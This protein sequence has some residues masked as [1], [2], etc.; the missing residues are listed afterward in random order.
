MTTFDM[1]SES[2]KTAAS[3]LE[4]RL[5]GVPEA[6]M[7][8]EVVSDFRSSKVRALLY[9]LAKQGQPQ[10][11]STLVALLWGDTLEASG[12]NSL[13]K[14][15]TNLRK[16]IPEFIVTDR[17][18]ASLN[19]E[20]SCHIDAVAF[21]GQTKVAVES[22]NIELLTETTNLYAGDFLEGF[23]V[24]DA[25]D[26]EEWVR[27]ERMRLSRVAASALSTL[28]EWQ[29]E[30]GDLEEAQATIRKSLQLEPWNEVAHQSLMNVLVAAGHRSAALAQYDQCCEILA[31]ELDV[32][33]SRQTKDLYEKIR[34]DQIEQPAR[35]R[36]QAILDKHVAVSSDE[37]KNNLP[38]QTTPFVGRTSEMQELYDLLINS[39]SRLITIVAPGGMGKTRLAIE[40]GIKNLSNYKDGVY[41]VPLV[42]LTNTDQIVENIADILSYNFASDN[43]TRR[44]QLRDYL[45]NK[46]TLLILDNFEHLL[47]NIDLLIDLLSGAPE[48]KFLVTSRERLSLSGETVYTLQGLDW[49]DD[50]QLASE[51]SDTASLFAQS[52]QRVRSDFAPTPEDLRAI[53]EIGQLVVG[54]PLAII[55]A[56]S[57][58]ELLSPAEIAADIKHGLD[59]LD[60]EL[61]DLPERQRSMRTVFEQT[62]QR[63]SSVEQDALMRLTVFRES[64]TREAAQYVSHAN[65][66]LLKS[67]VNK[68]LVRVTQNSRYD[69]QELLRQFAHEKTGSRTR[70]RIY[71][72]TSTQYLLLQ[73]AGRTPQ[74]F[75]VARAAQIL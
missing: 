42:A 36:Q 50:G 52:A 15:F 66:K 51:E 63:L 25:P 45:Q 44:Q 47:P 37:Q 62:W 39:H 73:L 68:S 17:A 70:Y 1:Y 6:R 49:S 48:I 32:E 43:R 74:R 21:E 24:A 10:S 12:R 35:T 53:F 13:N 5:L 33:P 7:N 54:M 64:F 41:F 28:S 11:R 75:P 29:I 16:L 18:T 26:F 65:L 71:S 14:A 38:T 60:A 8:G 3:L 59:L 22:R 46:N 34:S 69:I 58:I 72:Q 23:H 2:S 31:R 67:L 57:W 61:R 56:A 27:N 9:Y 30:D 55:L 40:V 4:I 20:S 19:V